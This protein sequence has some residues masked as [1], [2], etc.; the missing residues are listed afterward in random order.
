MILH[1]VDCEHRN[2]F[3]Y[4]TNIMYLTV[5][6]NNPNIPHKLYKGTESNRWAYYSTRQKKITYIAKFHNQINIPKETNQGN[7]HDQNFPT[8]K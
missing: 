7:F 8:Y 4:N 6:Q 2:Y 5:Q 3:L 1:T